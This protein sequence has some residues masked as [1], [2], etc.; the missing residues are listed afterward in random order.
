MIVN[1]N[2][3][4]AS[5]MG[6][7]RLQKVNV[8]EPYQHPIIANLSKGRDAKPWIYVPL[9]WDMTARPPKMILC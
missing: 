8:I 1:I 3:L 7:V 5:I 4:D 2:A 6:R 9:D